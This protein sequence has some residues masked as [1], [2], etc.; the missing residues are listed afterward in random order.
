MNFTGAKR[1]EILLLEK[2]FE[3]KRNE[4][5][6]QIFRIFSTVTHSCHCLPSKIHVT[7]VKGRSVCSMRLACKA[8][9]SPGMSPTVH[10]SVPS[11]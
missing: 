5:S 6:F 2:P 3:T 10:G 8:C 11:A 7:M 9:S 1:N 4:I